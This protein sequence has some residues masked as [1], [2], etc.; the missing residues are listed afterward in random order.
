M[1]DHPP[2]QKPKRGGGGVATRLRVLHG[3]SPTPEPSFRLL[4][5]VS[6]ALST[7]LDLDRTLREVLERLNQLVAFDAASLFLLDD[8]K[9]ELRVKAAIGV[10]VALKEVNTFKIGEGVVGWVVQHGTTALIEDSL[11]DARY[12]PTGAQR[13]PKTVLAAPLK[14]QH[15]VLGALVLVRAAKEPFKVEH[16]RLVEAIASQA[17]VA[18]DHARLFET[19]RASRR[20]AEALLAAAQASSEAV[21]TPELLRRAVK[22]VAFA[23]RATGAA[24]FLADEQGQAFEAAFE[25]SDSPGDELQELV[26]QPIATLALGRALLTADRPAV[27]EPGDPPG[28]LPDAAWS[29]LDAQAAVLVPVRWQGR[30]VAALLVGFANPERIE[31]AELELLEEIGR[32]VA[33]GI[34]RL[35]LQARVLD[36]QSQM[37]VVSERNRIARDMHDGIVQ[38]VYALGLGLEQ[39]R[40]L[41]AQEPDAARLLAAAVEQVN[42]VLSE[43]R[44]FIYQLRPIIMQEKE[45]GQWV[46]DLC[47]Q[48][49]QATGV[50]VVTAIGPSAGHEL[51]PEISIAIFRII[52]EALSNI[53]K[54]AR[55]NRARLSLDFADGAVRLSIEDD[56]TGLGG[57]R[58]P[59]PGIGQGRGLRNIEERVADLGGVLTLT[60]APGEGTRLEAV[61]PYERA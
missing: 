12:K 19:E 8:A 53:Y 37:S 58:R 24:V 2:I 32:Q 9:T 36:Q 20:R 41:V 50:T 30:L 40:D 14:A 61:F 5:Q 4:T 42:H 15:Q 44:T 1:T 59:G 34:E 48:F 52:Q 45:I 28:I 55:A 60:G 10:P 51:S 21:A 46:E 7:S 54:H 57:E 23:M 35:R 22:Q 43:M 39:A 13:A 17:A 3:G 25:A 27:L 26:R 56:G 38:Y 18:I 16:Q 11:K 33:L 47:R 6:A 49:Q 31:A 29:R